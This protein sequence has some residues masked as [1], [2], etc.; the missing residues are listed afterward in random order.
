MSMQSFWTHTFDMGTVSPAPLAL[1]LGILLLI[2]QHLKEAGID[3]SYPQRDLYIKQM[4]E[5]G[6]HPAPPQE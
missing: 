3:I 6:D 5:S 2:W 4:P 1:A